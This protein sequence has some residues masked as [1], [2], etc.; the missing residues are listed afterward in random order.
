MDVFPCSRAG[1]EKFHPL[2]IVQDM[3]IGVTD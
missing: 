2:S 1:R 3:R